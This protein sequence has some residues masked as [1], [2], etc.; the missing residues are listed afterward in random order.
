M[1]MEFSTREYEREHGKAPKGFGYWG[2]EFEG[3]TF[4]HSGTYTQAKKACRTDVKA[5]APNDY[6]GY[7]I[8][9][10]LP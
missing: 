5:K 10:V 4:W 8:I 3:Y 1:M 6:Q 2:F 9:N 7:V